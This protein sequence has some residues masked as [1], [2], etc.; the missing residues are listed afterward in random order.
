MLGRERP[1]PSC[2]MAKNN[3]SLQRPTGYYQGV[4]VRELGDVPFASDKLREDGLRIAFEP[5]HPSVVAISADAPL[6]EG[7][8]DVRR[9]RFFN[10]LCSGIRP[11]LL[12][13]LFR[14][15]QLSEHPLRN[16]VLVT[17]V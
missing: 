6:F 2:R 13:L 4:G 17:S 1:T 7:V 11:E 10:L 3:R 8:H 16:N 5:G 15:A 12:Q 14:V 9:S